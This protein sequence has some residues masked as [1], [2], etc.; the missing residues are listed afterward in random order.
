GWAVGS[1]FVPIV[2]LFVPVR[3]V[4]EIW[5]GTF[6]ALDSDNAREPKG[7][8]GLWW[9]CYLLSNG[10]NGVAGAFGRKPDGHYDLVGA[11]PFFAASAGLFV[12][13]ILL[14]INVFGK[15]SK[16]QSQLLSLNA[17]R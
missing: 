8:I 16:G 7:A 1:Y 2:N 12:V 4:G 11:A 6:E 14:F 13:A 17:F 5:R 9:T 3:A 15:L 10:L